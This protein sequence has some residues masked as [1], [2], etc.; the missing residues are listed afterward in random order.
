MSRTAI[1]IP[2]SPK[3]PILSICYP[4][5]SHAGFHGSLSLIQAHAIPGNPKMSLNISHS[6][7]KGST[8][9]ALH[10][11][12]FWDNWI[13]CRLVCPFC[14]GMTWDILLCYLEIWGEL[15]VNRTRVQHFGKDRQYVCNSTW[16]FLSNKCKVTKYDD[17]N[18]NYQ[19]S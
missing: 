2:F 14:P 9:M 5:T 15:R 7:H 17:T 1:D 12:I 13:P 6:I 11:E 19:G 3:C 18:K 10:F 8:H 16:T 4:G